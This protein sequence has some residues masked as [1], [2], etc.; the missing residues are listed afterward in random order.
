MTFD[1]SLSENGWL[2]L[3]GPSCSALSSSYDFTISPSRQSATTTS[4]DWTADCA[5]FEA[6]DRKLNLP[7]DLSIKYLIPEG[8]PIWKK[9]RRKA[10]ARR[11][12]CPIPKAGCWIRSGNGSVPSFGEFTFGCR[13]VRTPVS[14]LRP[15]MVVKSGAV[16]WCRRDKTFLSKE[17]Y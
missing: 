14:F 2:L 4:N 6:G 17:A 13:C 12:S 5:P 15:E 8:G 9:Q 7:F 16:V 3:A 10:R 1:L 11:S